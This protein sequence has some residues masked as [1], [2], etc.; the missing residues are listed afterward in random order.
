ML[1][2]ARSY[3][4]LSDNAD[5]SVQFDPPKLF[6][7]SFTTEL[8]QIAEGA[9]DKMILDGDCVDPSML[10]IPGAEVLRA[11]V[12]QTSYEDAMEEAKCLVRRRSI[13]LY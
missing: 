9:C 3:L 1:T 12:L 13:V 6:D 5:L 11:E 2:H 7:H 4:D 8:I 10:V